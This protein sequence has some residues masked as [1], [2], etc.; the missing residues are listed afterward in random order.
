MVVRRVF[1]GLALGG[2][3]VFAWGSTTAERLPVA[4]PIVVTRSFIEHADTVR[5]NETL[6]ELFARQG[7]GG[8]ELI[9]VL[10]ALDG[11]DP[12]RVQPR[13]VF[14]FTT[15]VGESH[16]EGIRVR[17]SR[18]AFAVAKLGPDGWRGAREEVTWTVQTL[19]I[20]GDIQSSLYETLDD[21][22]PDT[23]LDRPGRAQL[24]WDLADGVY[25]WEIDFTRD[26]RPGDRFTVLFEHLTSSLGERRYGRVLAANVQ[27][28]GVEHTAYVLSDAEGRNAYYNADGMSLRRAFKMYPVQ[29]RRISSNFNRGRMHPVLKTRR[30]HLGTDYAA[31][32][33]TPIEATA[34]GT[35]IRAGRWGGYGIMVGIRHVK[36]IETRY[37]HM[38][39]LAPGIRAGVR[40]RQG[41]VIGFV[42]MTGLASGPHVHYEFLKNGRQL[43]PRGVDLGDGEPVPAARREEFAQALAAFD[44]LLG[45]PGP[46]VARTD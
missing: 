10:D 5:R 15:P 42:G 6:S 2:L 41:D 33:G 26:I 31:D 13:T 27:T 22:V 17:V 40:V 37:A 14:E 20:V 4:A 43:N 18:D 45:R 23:V 7:I 44:G 28:A 34:D 32:Q 30:A 38:S 24:A 9:G 36:D 35:V 29:F 19:R 8:N 46:A 21:L 25:A 11:L 12:R 1:G 16:P 3:L 39:R